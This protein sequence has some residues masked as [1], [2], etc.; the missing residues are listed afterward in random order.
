MPLSQLIVN[1]WFSL[2]PFSLPHFRRKRNTIKV[3]DEWIEVSPLSL[4][5]TLTLVIL[6][7]PHI[8]KIEAHWSELQSGLRGNRGEL[9]ALLMALRQEMAKTPGDIV[10][11]FALLT[12]QDA[13]WIARNASAADLVNALPVLDKV[14]DFGLLWTSIKALGL[15]VKYGR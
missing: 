9:S 7:A 3:G 13:D 12:G 8:A 6:L 11:A 4:E 2:S 14:N 10:A 5:A 15:T 1:N